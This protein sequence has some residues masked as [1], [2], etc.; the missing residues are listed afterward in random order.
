M[1]GALGVAAFIFTFAPH[2][3]IGPPWMLAILAGLALLWV[4][5]QPFTTV[6]DDVLPALAVVLSALG[7]AVVAR[8][9]PELAQKQQLWLMVSLV[10]AI[11]AAPLFRHFRQFASYKYLWVIASLL[12]F[13]AL[14]LFGQEVNGARL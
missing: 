9:S 10:L 11:A 2:G 13:V 14:L 5:W 6:R 8:L 3:T 12:L 1:I 4:L 7:L